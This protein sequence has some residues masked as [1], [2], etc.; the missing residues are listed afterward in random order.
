MNLPSL[1]KN[2]RLIILIGLIGLYLCYIYAFYQPLGKQLP[3]EQ[4][5]QTSPP[6]Q[7]ALA[8]ASN[9]TR[10]SQVFSADAL[11]V[12]RTM[13]INNVFV[14]INTIIM[15]YGATI[16]PGWAECDGQNGT[17]DLRGRFPMAFNGKDSSI[18]NRIG[19]TGGQYNVRLSEAQM[20]KHFHEG[21]TDPA[22]IHSSTTGCSAGADTGA[23]DV[24]THNHTIVTNP[25]G[26]SA[27]HNNM[28]R[29]HVLKFLI[30]TI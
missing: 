19:N 21:T 22:G 1:Q 18:A 8:S 2:Q 16:P 7:R 30:K 9:P 4:N 20:P 25:A 13:D 23:D 5:I 14:P 27:E 26:S 15:W 11:G 10:P 6:P 24:G 12:I 28:P 29:Y 3:S 17:P